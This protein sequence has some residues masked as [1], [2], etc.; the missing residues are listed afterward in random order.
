LA[1]RP[2]GLYGR[3]P[4]VPTMRSADGNTVPYPYPMKSFASSVLKNRNRIMPVV[5]PLAMVGATTAALM[6]LDV[7]LDTERLVFGYLVPTTLAAIA[8]GSL[9]G[10]FTAIVSA[11]CAAYFLYPPTFALWID[12]RLHVVELV[13]FAALALTASYIVGRMAN[14]RQD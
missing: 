11:V 10:T 3:D 12:N 9:T 2:A 1:G 6:A 7:F 14:W 5:L 13:I 4:D 8:Y